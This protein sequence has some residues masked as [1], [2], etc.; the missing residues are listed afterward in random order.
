[1]VLKRIKG[2]HLISQVQG[3]MNQTEPLPFEAYIKLVTLKW[4]L[5]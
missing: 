5:K 3:G 4:V 1:M 2:H